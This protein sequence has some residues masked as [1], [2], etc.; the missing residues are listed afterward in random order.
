MK[1]G[2]P[3][4]PG[5][6]APLS[7]GTRAFMHRGQPNF[8]LP[9]RS[10]FAAPSST[11]VTTS[12]ATFWTIPFPRGARETPCTC[13]SGNV[14]LTKVTQIENSRYPSGP[15]P[16]QTRE[17]LGRGSRLPAGS[18]A[19]VFQKRSFSKSQGTPTPAPGG[20]SLK[21]AAPSGAR[22]ELNRLPDCRRL[23]PKGLE[24]SE[25]LKKPTTAT[26]RGRESSDTKS[27]EPMQVVD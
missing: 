3:R 26:P 18:A 10:C 15:L 14:F 5:K 24:D 11:C 22:A 12:R 27:Q 9:G 23:P 19:A 7:R 4:H 6:G 13:L 16:S 17:A 21:P 20:P 25:Y 2:Q 8:H 1:A